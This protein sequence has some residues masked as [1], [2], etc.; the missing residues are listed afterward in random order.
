M[1]CGILHALSEDEMPLLLDLI[2]KL[3]SEGIDPHC[4]VME[5][6]KANQLGFTT[7]VE[8]LITTCERVVVLISSGLKT[9]CETDDQTSIMFDM[10]VRHI[11][12]HIPGVKRAGENTKFVFCFFGNADEQDIPREP[13]G[14]FV[15]MHYPKEETKLVKLILGKEWFTF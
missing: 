10:V 5:L 12:R 6:C 7:Y 15:F 14:D 1:H 9:K 13:I 11:H 8:Q 3:S 2:Q 4:D